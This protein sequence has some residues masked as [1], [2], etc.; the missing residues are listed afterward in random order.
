MVK[1]HGIVQVTT[2]HN[3]VADIKASRLNWNLVV[4]VVRMYELPLL[5]NPNDFYQEFIVQTPGRGIRTTSHRFRLTFYQKTSVS[6]LF[7]DTFPFSPFHITPFLGVLVMIEVRQF[8]L[9]D[10][11]GHVVRK[12]DVI[13]MVTRN[14][15]ASK[16]MAVY[17]EDLEFV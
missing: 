14:G 10:C 1:A 9:I 11:L 5:S 12:E 15:D 3:K 2:H 8:H 4:R 16:R 13:D 6:R 17:L 7:S